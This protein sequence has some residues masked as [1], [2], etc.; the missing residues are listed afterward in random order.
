MA[1][2]NAGG[3]V[4]NL[5]DH[6]ADV[7]KLLSET[8]AFLSRTDEF[9]HYENQLRAW[10]AALQRKRGDAESTRQVRQEITELRKNLRLQGHDLSLAREQLRFEGFRND[11]C[12]REGFKRL[13]LAFTQYGAFWLS[14]DDN[15]VALSDFLDQRLASGSA[16][17]KSAHIRERHYLWYRRRAHELVLSGS[18]TEIK[19]DFD[20]LRAMGEANS[21]V[22]LKMLKGLK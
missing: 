16:A 4:A 18:D 11:S 21:L 14:G 20:H 22:L 7:W 1:K 17:Q 13:V 10:R 12:V 2:D 5:S 8:T 6:F 9:I 3:F 15:H 19:E